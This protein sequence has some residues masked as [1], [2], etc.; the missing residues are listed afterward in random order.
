MS[1]KVVT[2]L[3][4]AFGEM[5]HQTV[6]FNFRGVGKSEGT[7]GEAIGEIDDLLAVLAW[8][9]ERFPQHKVWLAGFSFGSYITA[10]V[11]AEDHTIEQLISIA[12]P[13]PAN[14]FN[15]QHTNHAN[16]ISC[17]WLVVMGEEDEVVPVEDVRKWLAAIKA[18]IES[19]F[20]P[21]VTHFFHG[22]LTELRELLK[23]R[24][25]LPLSL[26]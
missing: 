6:R 14:Y 11:A 20:L 25:Q 7:Y 23:Q 1:N 8:A 3:A 5:G 13:T 9:K 21:G 26:R 24:L 15:F 17:P 12:P 22:K 16:E 10:A 2:T 19:V 4:R 18:P